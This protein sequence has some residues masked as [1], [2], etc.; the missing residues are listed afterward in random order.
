MHPKA[1]RS[2]LLTGSFVLGMLTWAPESLAQ[3]GAR[4]EDVDHARHL[5]VPQPGLYAP[6][7]GVASPRSDS[8]NAGSRPAILLTG[9]WP[10]TNEMIRH[11]STDP[12][13]SR[14]LDGFD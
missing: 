7:A 13:Q 6:G 2:V 9:Y 14:R 10:P 4:P 1:F 11:F 3:R 8:L 12:V 5:L